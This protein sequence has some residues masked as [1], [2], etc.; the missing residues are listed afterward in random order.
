MTDNDDDYELS[1]PDDDVADDDDQNEYDDTGGEPYQSQLALRTEIRLAQLARERA[2][3]GVPFDVSW[4]ISEQKRQS[5]AEHERQML[6]ARARK[7]A[8]FQREDNAKIEQQEQRH[9]RQQARHL[10]KVEAQRVTNAIAAQDR[11]EREAAARGREAKRIAHE[12]ALI[13]IDHMDRF[14]LDR[15]HDALMAESPNAAIAARYRGPFD[16][17]PDRVGSPPLVRREAPGAIMH[18]RHEDA[19]VSPYATAGGHLNESESDADFAAN[20]AWLGISVEAGDAIVEA[21]LAH[22]HDLELTIGASTNHE[23][24]LRKRSI[25]TLRKKLR[26]FERRLRKLE[27]K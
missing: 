23:A 12:Q 7:L 18:K 24:A 14:A 16:K 11:A 1:L 26:D 2:N 15:M 17:A 5:Q 10:A 8:R 6:L 3:D 9:Q 25:G 22:K 13:E 19:L 27:D 4:R 21:L 20:C